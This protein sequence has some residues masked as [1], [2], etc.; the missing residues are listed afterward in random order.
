MFVMCSTHFV[1]PCLLKEQLMNKLIWSSNGRKT[2]I[3]AMGI[4]ST[5]SLIFCLICMHQRN[6]QK[7]SGRHWTT[8]TKLSNESYPLSNYFDFKMMNNKW[9]RRKSTNLL[10]NVIPL[11]NLLSRETIL[12]FYFQL[13]DVF[14]HTKPT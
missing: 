9:R 11:K 14:S 3:H 4:F 8:N 12:S 2:T 10:G 1:R 6:L 5:P 13:D 7:R